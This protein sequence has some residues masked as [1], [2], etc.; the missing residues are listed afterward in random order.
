[1]D[2]QELED[3]DTLARVV[4]LILRELIWCKLR[5]RE[6]FYIHFGWDYYMYSGGVELD[7]ETRSAI[8]DSGLFVERFKS[9]Y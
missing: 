8:T 7:T 4:R 1:V 3:R 5:A 6:G 9:P 2:D